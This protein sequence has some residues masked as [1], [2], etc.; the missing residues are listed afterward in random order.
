M[1]PLSFLPLPLSLPPS[2]SLISSHSIRLLFSLSLHSLYI[3]PRITLFL[4]LTQPLLP[5]SLSPC[6]FITTLPISLSLHLNLSVFHAISFSSTTY[7][8]LSPSSLTLFLFLLS[9]NIFPSLTPLSLPLSRSLP[10]SLSPSFT[11]THPLSRKLGSNASVKKTGRQDLADR[12]ETKRYVRDIF[13]GGVHIY[14]KICLIFE[15]GAHLPHLR[16][17][18]N[19]TQ[20]LIIQVYS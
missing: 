14:E 4:D 2:L 12:F 11:F 3:F 6:L 5:L 10:L 17:R 13:Y 9:H 1:W 7:Y 16:M 15:L 20:A 19:K 8:H 18:H